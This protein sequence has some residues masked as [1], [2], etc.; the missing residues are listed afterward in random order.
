MDQDFDLIVLVLG[1]G[2]EAK[3]DILHAKDFGD[4]SSRLHTSR[5]DGLNDCLKVLLVVRDNCGKFVR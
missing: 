1:Q 5:M 3:V 4:H 2:F